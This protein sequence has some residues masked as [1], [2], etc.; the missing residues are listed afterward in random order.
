MPWLRLHHVFALAVWAG[1]VYWT[2]WETRALESCRR[3]PDPD[4]NVRAALA[5]DQ[6]AAPARPTLTPLSPQVADAGPPGSGGAYRCRTEAH[7][8]HKP[9]DL[10]VLHPA[11]QP[12]APRAYCLLSLTITLCDSPKLT[13]LSSQVSRR[14]ASSSTARG[15]V[16]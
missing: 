5:P 4:Y 2:D 14:Y 10:R 9:M 12:P 16:C 13:S 6:P 3:V 1:R 7:T 15:C 8:V 11:R